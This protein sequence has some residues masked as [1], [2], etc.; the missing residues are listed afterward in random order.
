MLNLNYNVKIL[1]LHL[2]QLLTQLKDFKF[3]TKLVL[4]FRN[5]ES[6]D[7]TSHDTFYSNSKAEI[8]INKSDIDGVFKSTYTTVISNI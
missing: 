1:N 4:M 3:V 2:T 8:I 6:G 7:K 5:V